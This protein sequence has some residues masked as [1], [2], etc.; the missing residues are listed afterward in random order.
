MNEHE[1]KPQL[2][3]T[4]KRPMGQTLVD[5]FWNGEAW[6]CRDTVRGRVFS[7]KEAEVLV[8]MLDVLKAAVICSVAPQEASNVCEVIQC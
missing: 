2:Q 8:A 1:S 7:A 4:P 3:D 5:I 6:V